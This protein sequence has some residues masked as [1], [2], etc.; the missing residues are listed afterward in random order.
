MGKE[1]DKSWKLEFKVCLTLDK[2]IK[3]KKKWWVWIDLSGVIKG[4]GITCF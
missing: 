4:I 2:K 3:D 1:K